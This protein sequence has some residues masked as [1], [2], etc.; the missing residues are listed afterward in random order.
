[1]RVVETMEEVTI[2]LEFIETLTPLLE[3][4]SNIDVFKGRARG[5]GGE[6]RVLIQAPE[7]FFPK[8]LLSTVGIQWYYEKDL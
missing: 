1:M 4:K 3:G 2:P 5:K 6:V 7:G 8:E